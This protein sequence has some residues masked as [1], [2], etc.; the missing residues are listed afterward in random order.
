MP[1]QSGAR[2]TRLRAGFTLVEMMIAILLTVL[3]FAMTV[4]FFR[5]Q[6]N[7]VD[8]SAGRL[9]ALQNARYAQ[10]A[11]DRELRLAGGVPGQPVIVQASPFAITF[12]VDLVSRIVNDPNSIYLDPSAD[13]LAT[14]S[15]E[16]ARAKTLPGSAKPYPPKLYNDLNGVQSPAE[17][18]SYMVY[19]DGTA[20]RSDLYILYRR[21]ND[22][23]SVV[24]ARNL[25]IPTDTNYFFHYYKTDATGVIT[26][27]PQASLPIYWDAANAPA[28]SIRLVE[29]RIA[30]LYRDVKKATDVIKTVYHKTRL[31][32]AGMLKE[33]TCGSP[34]LGPVSVTA[35]MDTNALGQVTDINVTWTRSL[36]ELSGEADVATYLVMRRLTTV[37]DWEVLGNLVAVGNA[38]YTFLDTNF[39]PGTWIYGV[40]A[41]DCTPA[42]SAITT[43][44]NLTI[45]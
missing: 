36:E 25:W 35:Q 41:Q 5:L 22:R 44:A 45:P 7:A 18:V 4:P 15:W 13:S 14:E 26:M 38:S 42:N 24:I 11:I 33:R 19:L 34:P 3:V 28:D 16:P 27:I 23:D 39:K 20:G 30:G 32:N 9:D 6:T 37:T 43:A 17:T 12:N 1:D 10:N 21:I 2:A 29:M 8:V 31:L 40:A